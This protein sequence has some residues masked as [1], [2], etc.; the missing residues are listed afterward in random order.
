LSL[1]SEVWWLICSLLFFISFI[2]LFFFH[3]FFFVWAAWGT[4]LAVIWF[5]MTLFFLVC[6]FP[7]LWFRPESLFS[8]WVIFLGFFVLLLLFLLLYSIVPLE[9]LVY[10][11]FIYFWEHIY[12]QFVFNFGLGFSTWASSGW[13]LFVVL[14][15]IGF[16]SLVGLYFIRLQVFRIFMFIFVCGNN[17]LVGGL[18]YV[19]MVFAF[20]VKMPMFMVHLWLPR[21]HVEAPVSGS[22]ILA[23]VLLK[24][25]G[26]GFLRVFPVLFKFGLRLVLFELF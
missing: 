15:F 16:S 12:S 24:L 1:F 21:A 20:L 26:Y 11:H 14:Y 3:Y 9:E 8:V 19:C 10:F 5:L 7:F 22:I 6:E 18:F 2:Y 13:D 4:F 25:G 23:G 17:S